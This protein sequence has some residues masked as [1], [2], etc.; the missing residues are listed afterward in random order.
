MYST[1]IDRL[2]NS[3]ITK[4]SSLRPFY[5]LLSIPY[6]FP[7]QILLVSQHPNHSNPPSNHKSPNH[8]PF[9]TSIALPRYRRARTTVINNPHH[10]IK[11]PLQSLLLPPHNFLPLLPNP[12]NSRTRITNIPLALHNMFPI[13]A[14]YRKGE[15]RVR[16]SGDV[17]SGRERGVGGLLGPG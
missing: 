15:L 12:C 11:P 5:F 16:R 1:L 14:Q 3:S 10:P 6:S 13:P 7:R 8:H 4:H 17:E 2:E 9:P